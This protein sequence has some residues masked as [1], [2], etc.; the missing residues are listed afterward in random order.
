MWGVLEAKVYLLWV[1]RG[2]AEFPELKRVAAALLLR[3]RPEAL[4]VEDASAGTSLIQEFREA[5]TIDERVITLAVQFGYQDKFEQQ[6]LSPPIL[7][8][9]VDRD[10]LARAEAITPLIERGDVLLPDPSVYEVPW[11]PAY[12]NE[13]ARFTGVD[14][15]HDDQVDSTTQLLNYLRG[16]GFA[17]LMD[18]YRRRAEAAGQH[19]P[20]ACARCQRPIL[21][22]QQYT[23]ERDRKSHVSCP[24]G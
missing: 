17:N 15:L 3:W 8:I 1:W 22:G 11:L 24:V 9:Q 12:L 6:L 13:F 20:N 2:K 14:D 16:G 7:P 10:K 18:F 4:L 21:D 5:I 19:N 23:R